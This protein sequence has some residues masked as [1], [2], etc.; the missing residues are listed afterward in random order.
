MSNYG[1]KKTIEIDGTLYSKIDEWCRLNGLEM[2]K[3]VEKTLREKIATEKYGDLN[4]KVKKKPKKKDGGATV[5]VSA[6][7]SGEGSGGT[8]YPE[9]S[10]EDVVERAVG[11]I[12][13]ADVLVGEL[14]HEANEKPSESDSV[15]KTKRILKSK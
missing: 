3:F 10:I 4:D 11:E 2:N 8:S 14:E 12:K 5:S 13:S 15:K 9:N 1:S 7:L 6:N